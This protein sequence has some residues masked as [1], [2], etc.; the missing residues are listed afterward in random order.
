MNRNTHIGSSF[1]DFLAEEDI[2]EE[3][4]SIAAKRVIAWQVA[5]AMKAAKLTKTALARRM[6]TSR[7]QLDR[8]LDETDTGLTLD[9]LS[10]TATALGYRI[11]IELVVAQTKKPGKRSATAKH[12]A[13][14]NAPT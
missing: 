2:L 7:S 13:L 1:D 8:V 11:Q 3:A 5:E 4:A 12:K 6:N 14:T 10:R 9:T